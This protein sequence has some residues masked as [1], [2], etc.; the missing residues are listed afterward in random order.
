MFEIEYFNINLEPIR[1][2]NSTVLGFKPA[3]FYPTEKTK[4]PRE[5]SIQKLGL[6][7]F[8]GLFDETRPPDPFKCSSFADGRLLS[9]HSNEIN[10][11]HRLLPP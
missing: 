5:H 11:F 6:F 4:W 7:F 10:L 3:Y 1:L 2:D 9:L 8:P